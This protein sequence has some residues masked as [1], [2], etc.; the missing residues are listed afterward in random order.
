M[1]DP[2]SMPGFSKDFPKIKGHALVHEVGHWFGLLHTF[3]GSTDAD[4][5]G[6]CKGDGDFIWDTPA[7]AS[8][9]TKCDEVC[10]AVSPYCT[11]N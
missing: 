1:L 6:G 8:P 10:S 7:E 11:A 3:E 4:P 9:S 2:V 5:N